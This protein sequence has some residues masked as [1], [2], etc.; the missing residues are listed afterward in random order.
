MN[1]PKTIILFS[2]LVLLLNGSCFGPRMYAGQTSS[3]T[4]P[5]ARAAADGST[6]SDSQ[7]W[8]VLAPDVMGDERDPSLADAAQ[9]SYRYD[10]TQDMLWFRVSLYGVP[11]EKAFGVNLVVDTGGDDA[12]KTNWWGGNK[13]FR[14]DKI[15]TAWVTRGDNGYEGT[16]GVG[17][18]AGVQT[19]QINNLLQNNL[20]VAVAGDS[21]VIGVKRTDITDSLKLNLLAAVG[22]N[23]QWNDDIPNTGS[24]VVDLTTERPKQGLREI[25][26]ARN[27]FEFPTNYKTLPDDKSAL[28]TKIGSG[29]QT[30]ILVPGMY[31]G[32]HSFDDF[33][34]RNKSRYKI[35]VVTPPGING[36]LPRPIP[37]LHDNFSALTWTRRLEQDILELIGKERIVKPVVVSES[38][39]ASTAAMELAVG[40]P[41]KIGGVIVSGTNLVQ[42]FPSPSDPAR[43]RLA[44][45][46]ERTA[47]VNQAWAAKWFKFVTPETWLSNDLRAQSLA[48]DQ[49]R[50]QR[51]WNEIEAA[52][53]PTKI[54]YLCEF[55]ASDVTTSFEKLH[56]P[57]MAL[58]AGF[59]DEFLNEP[60]NRFTKLAY[61]DSWETLVPKNP[62]VDVVKIR[63]ARLLIF[64][65]QPQQA[66]EAVASFIAKINNRPK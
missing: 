32:S 12:T 37:S 1:V 62:L 65:D 11:N 48:S 56:V 3:A 18:T 36:T 61:V 6:R 8:T 24:V 59:D 26:L 43:K 7:I 45:P 25:D 4:P 19:R 57:V 53:L 23:E 42:Y 46:A 44:N 14:F 20:H 52:S 17:D 30:L 31:S 38:Y 49:A 22:S 34:A 63:G 40:H 51:A 58:V 33:I 21:I 9:L 35:F 47:L 5:L 55:W 27:N 15:I 66:E 64:S 39:P 28:V 54:R 60:A 16:I 10:K 50:G 2:F 13:A 41:E 29:K